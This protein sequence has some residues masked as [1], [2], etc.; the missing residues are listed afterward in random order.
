[1]G[2]TAEEVPIRG[3]F[4]GPRDLTL[5]ARQVKFEQL[6]FWLNPIGAV[7]TI[8]FSVVFIVIFESTSRYSTVSFLPVVLGQYYIPSFA[9]YGIMAACFNILA[10]QLVN[11]REM[12]L[13]KR[14]RLSPLPT[15]VL[16]AA[17]FVNSVIVAGIQLVLLLLVGRF[18]YHVH[19]P[20]DIGMF[21]LV[22]LVGM[23]SFTALG[24]GVATLV[25]N[26]DAAGPI[27]SLVFFILVGLSGLYFPVKPGSGLATFAD[28][29]PI[30]HLIIASVDSFNGLA[31]G[32]VWNDLLVIALWG[33]AGVVLALRRWEWSPKRG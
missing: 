2:S 7:L 4:W 12:G 21:I 29:F 9:A 6:S 1:M 14:L 23:A 32:S 11:R 25:P 20:H 13:L 24:V 26:A 19:G 15:W 8:G 30:R 31:G 5:V 27:V 17:I 3:S 22:V 16:L 28:V 33:V 18:G 10:I